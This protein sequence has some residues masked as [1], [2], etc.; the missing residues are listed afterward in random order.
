MA[1]YACRVVAVVEVQQI[2]SVE[3]PSTGESIEVAAK[4]ARSMLPE[5]PPGLQWIITD[6]HIENTES[7]KD[8][9]QMS[10]VQELP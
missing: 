10:R 2:F 3:A 8:T 5:P 6:L 7:A 1:Q 9:Y 4:K